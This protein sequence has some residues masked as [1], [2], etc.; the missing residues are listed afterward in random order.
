MQNNLINIDVQM[1]SELLYAHLLN[2]FTHLNW[3]YCIIVT[4][5]LVWMVENHDYAYWC[6]KISVSIL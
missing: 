2:I 6:R 5:H 1:I 3:I 4:F